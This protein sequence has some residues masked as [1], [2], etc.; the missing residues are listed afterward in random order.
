MQSIEEQAKNAKEAAAQ[1]AL[2]SPKDKSNALIAMAQHLQQGRKTLLEANQKDLVKAKGKNK[3]D[4]F[5]DRMTLTDS[6]IDGMIAGIQAIAAMND[7]VG[8]TLKEWTVDSGLQFKRVSIPIGVVAIIYESRPNVT[9]D[10][11]ALCL[12]SGNAVILRG[13]SDCVGTN[14]AIATL[15]QQALHTSSLPSDSIQYI[16]NQDHA[17]V[18]TLLGLDQYIDVIV[19][20]GGK[21]L[22]ARVREKSRVPVFSHLEGLCHTYVHADADLKMAQAIVLNAK[23]RRTGICG[24]TETLLVDEAIA[25]KFLPPMLDALIDQGCVIKGDDKTQRIDARVSAASEEDWSTEYLSATLSV[26][27]VTDSDEAIAHINRYATN[28]TEAIITNNQKMADHFQHQ[29][30]SAIV[31]HNCSTQFADGGEFGMGAEIGIA[32]GKLH[33]RGPV[34]IN[35]LTTYKTLVMGSG[36]TRGA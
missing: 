3:P 15:L 21:S 35:E 12:K 24:A 7:P 16:A 34:G 19:P 8:R 5:I 31:M 4:A 17:G 6:V 14:R 11:A 20:R 1:L 25:K 26:R 18:D 30:N 36:H 2:C 27:I 9:A 23:L 29:I 13:G 28:H 10:A 32:T 22:I 33:A